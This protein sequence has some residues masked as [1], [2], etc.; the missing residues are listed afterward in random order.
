M[1]IIYR[2]KQVVG[3][4]PFFGPLQQSQSL[5]ES[6]GAHASYGL[7]KASFSSKLWALLL[8][9]IKQCMLHIIATTVVIEL[10]RFRYV[11]TVA[12]FS[13]NVQTK[14]DT[15][16]DRFGNG[17]RTFTGSFPVV[18]EIFTNEEVAGRF[19]LRRIVRYFA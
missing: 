10:F 19:M 4:I 18:S 5:I 9:P 15:F 11:F 1:R 2:P 8:L 12:L 7:M 3:G 14:G 6:T 17:E 13:V 16:N